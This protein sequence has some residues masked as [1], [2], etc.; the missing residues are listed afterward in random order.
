[1]DTHGWD[2]VFVV[3]IDFINRALEKSTSELL[4][5]FNFSE[6]GY[7]VR[8][9]FGAWSIVP[10][11]GGKLLWLQLPVK[12]GSISGGFGAAVDITG[13]T[14]VVQVSLA[15]LPAPG[16]APGQMLQ[17]DF[18]SVG[19]DALPATGA[20]V[21]SPVEV[22]DPTGR[23]T[24]LL[25][26]QIGLAVAQCLVSRAANISF[27]FATLNPL[28]ADAVPWLKPA[29]SDYCYGVLSGQDKP[30]LA[31]LSV[32]DARDTSALER[33]VD[34]S[35]LAAGCD[36][37]LA[38][39][40]AMFLQNVLA[41][42]LGRSFGVAATT[43]A[44]SAPNT[45]TAGGFDL[46]R[47]SA[48]GEHYYPKAD[49]LSAIVEDDRVAIT[50]SG[51]CSMGMGISMTFNGSS[52]IGVDFD[53]VSQALSFPTIGIPSFSHD[54]DVPWY[55]YAAGAFMLGLPDLILKIVV[56]A[57]SSSLGHS[58]A[59]SVGSGSISGTAAG[60]VTWAGMAE[61]K[62]VQGGLATAFY[63]RFIASTPTLVLADF[64]PIDC[65]AVSAAMAAKK[66]SPTAW[67]LDVT[68]TR[69]YGFEGGVFAPWTLA[70]A[71]YDMGTLDF[72]LVFS[73]VVL[74]G[75]YTAGSQSKP[76]RMCP[77]H[78][79]VPMAFRC[80]DA[81]GARLF[82]LDTENGYWGPV[83]V[84]FAVPWPFLPQ[85]D[86]DAFMSLLESWLGDHVDLF[87]PILSIIE[88]PSL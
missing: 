47:V 62:P 77:L 65:K 54:T 57:V 85:D 43:F 66:V 22:S 61:V 67:S 40:A 79:R 18:Q 52:I 28:A 87:R 50:L 42:A 82:A 51:S 37:G 44:V 14:V 74:S 83:E 27:I 60:I 3:D 17:F 68:E 86:K 72:N 63:L 32:N 16:G 21:V 49:A 9:A 26:K 38:I 4:T 64:S 13:A 59:N 10:G 76:I 36:A 78:V 5:T 84:S 30:V 88:N 45:L 12:S 46:E 55:D 75:T 71:S 58:L 23:L 33:K 19:D 70:S 20:G 80:K 31:I 34:P 56:D 25:K 39:S 1:M 53:L 73:V 35:I 15:L 29:S 11:G 81:A 7:E 48:A 6:Q 69:G 41:P 8:G 2:T 24:P